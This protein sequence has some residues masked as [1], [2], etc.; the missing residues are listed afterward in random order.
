MATF[1]EFRKINDTTFKLAIGNEEVEIGNRDAAEFK[2]H[3]KLKRWGDECWI[4]VEY[5]T[6]K[7]IT[8]IQEDDKIKWE[9]ADKETYFYLLEPRE[10]EENGRIVKQLEQGGFEFEIILKEKPASNKIVL[11]IETQGLKFHYQPDLKNKKGI[12]QPENTIGSYAVYHATKRNIHPNQEEADKY[13]TGKA[14]HIYRPK[15]TDAK[16]NWT[17][18]E[19]H[20]DPEKGLLT[21]TIPQEFLDKAVYP[22]SSTGINFGYEAIGVITTALAVVD[23]EIRTGNFY[24]SPNDGTLDSITTYIAGDTQ[25]FDVKVFVN[26]KDSVE[27]GSHGQIATATRTDIPVAAAWREF[28]LSNEEISADTDYILNLIGRYETEETAVIYSDTVK[29]DESDVTGYIDEEGEYATPENPWVIDLYDPALGYPAW[30]IETEYA[31]YTLVHNEFALYQCSDA[32]T[33]TA[34]KEPG[35][36]V[37][38]EDYWTHIT[39]LDVFYASIYCTYTPV[40][41]LEGM[42]FGTEGE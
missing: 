11:D 31:Q 39:D 19:L 17:W 4:K 30:A 32:H 6:T 3:A 10:Y 14:F 33:S 24:A 16:G 20:I 23:A 2:P 28:T 40:V 26:Q 5:P 9:D 21:I 15:I 25:P 36:G 1:G 41:P 34:D 37:N 29:W 18:E 7:K 35:V 12:F 22:V 13:K 27:V 38:W 8:P 42:L